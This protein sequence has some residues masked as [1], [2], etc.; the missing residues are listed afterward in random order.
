M[1]EP[2]S[3]R[4]DKRR[5]GAEVR[6]WCHGNKEMLGYSTHMYSTLLGPRAQGV[7]QLS[8]R[9]PGCLL[10]VHSLFQGSHIHY[11]LHACTLL[12][13]LH[14]LLQPPNL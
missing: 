6:G 11:K 4:T 1:Y 12:V 7:S 5:G 3:W 8:L 13:Y 14:K 9:C 10:S 2:Y